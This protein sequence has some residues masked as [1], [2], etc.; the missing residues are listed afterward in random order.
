MA[1]DVPV[2]YGKVVLRLKFMMTEPVTH[3]LII[4]TP[5]LVQLRARIDMYSQTVHVRKDGKTEVLNLVSESEI[6]N[7]TDD[8]LTADT[9]RENEAGEVWDKDEFR[10]FVMTLDA[11]KEAKNEAEEVELFRQKVEHL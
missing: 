9:E 10:G 8:E 11:S 3:D 5:A 2:G 4:G 6:F 1:S 7:D